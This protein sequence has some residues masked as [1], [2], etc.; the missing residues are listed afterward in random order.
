MGTIPGPIISFRISGPEL[1]GSVQPALQQVRQQAK[2]IS[3]GIADDWKRMA[4]QIRA[5]L[6]SGLSTDKESV[7]VRNQL[8]G[9]LDRQIAGYNKLNELSTKELSSLKAVTLERERQ[10]DAIRRGVGVGV[11][12]GTSSALGQVSAQTV[13]GIERI[14]DSVINRY[15]GGAAGAAARTVRDVGYYAGQASGNQSANPLSNIGAGL[16]GILGSVS[17][18]TLAVGALVTSFAATAGVLGT[19]T[20]SMI[21]Y[22]QSVQ[23]VS[24]A[25][26]LSYSETQKFRE[27]AK[28]T[29]VDAD[30]LTQSFGRLQAELGK[31]VIS[32]KD[33]E[34]ATQNFVKVLDRFGISATDSGGKLRP[35]GSIISDF[36][37]SLS[38]IPDAET[39]T[40]IGMDAMGTRG[41]ILV[42]VIDNLRASGM[43]LKQALDEVTKATISDAKIKELLA[44]KKS[45]DDL[46]VSVDAATLHVKSFIATSKNEIGLGGASPTALLSLEVAKRIS[47]F[48]TDAGA[49]STTGIPSAASAQGLIAEFAA[50]TNKLF[51]ERAEIIKDGGRA[52]YELLQ[53][54]QK[55]G[56]AVKASHGEDAKK[57]ADEIVNLK[58]VI[59]LQKEN[60]KYL[61]SSSASHRDFADF[62]RTPP[63]GNLGPGRDARGN[64]S[65]LSQFYNPTVGVDPLSLGIGSGGSTDFLKGIVGPAGKAPLDAAGLLAQ[66]NKEHEDLFKSQAAIDAEHYQ[67][68]LDSLNEALKKQLI[69]QQEY[70]DSVTKLAQDRNKTLSDADKKYEDEAGSLFDDLISG[71]GKKF[72][73]SLLKDVTDSALAPVKS[74]FEN[75]VGGQLKSVTDLFGGKSPSSP[76]GAAPSGGFLGGIFGKIGSLFGVGG[77][78]GTFPGAI[79]SGSGVGVGQSSVMN[80][81]AGVVNIMQG[82]PGGS[83][84]P[85]G[86]FPGDPFS[87]TGGTGGFGDFFGNTN[88]FGTAGG[89]L[90][91]VVSAATSGSSLGNVLGKLSPFAA[92][93]ALLGL[94]IGTGNETAIAM[95]AA[96]LASKAA[97]ALNT[98]GGVPSGASSFLSD[99]GSAGPGLGLAASGIITADKSNTV[100]G[101]AGGTFEAAAGGALAGAQFGGPIGAAIGW[102]VGLIGGVIADIFGGGPQGF[103]ASVQAAMRN[104][105]Y[106]APTSENFSFASNGSIANTLGTGFIQSGGKFSQYALPSNTSFAA[107]ALTG[108]LTWQQLYQLQNSG[109]NPNAPFLGNPSQNPYIGQGPVGVHATTPAPAVQIHVNLPGFVDASSAAA[110]FTPHA[111]LLTRLISA[112]LSSSSSGFGN[113]VRRAAYLP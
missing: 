19:V 43:T 74:I 15:L 109:L 5:S 22:A 110:A 30:G 75:V 38:E 93:G 79:G 102:S 6:A 111:Q 35:I 94:G 71:N 33:S 50:Q 7:G 29:G 42:Q 9:I 91:A 10:A 59:E 45:W 100:A 3:D 66:I 82:G 97:N 81:Q 57:Y 60:A 31:Y 92:G 77:T 58:A 73:T 11:T 64:A 80:V 84:V 24:A 54:E 65:A 55:Y 44:E 13:Q 14:L 87:G 105:Q 37:M 12:A 34:G 108:N 103:Q 61:F 62:L 28:I 98:I 47:S 113:N 69:S 107:S 26:G 83:L 70:N 49:P 23:N 56:E 52:E 106:H 99:F 104:N 4:A 32:G 17:P 2:S 78:P 36:A 88:P 112:Q 40:A 48:T 96:N 89:G 86:S 51:L 68:E 16:S 67:D 95:G 63:T 53:A 20:H 27:L 25:T 18:A 21:G 8:L 46:V 72:G 41:K 90:G 76:S 1:S 85:G 39:R 101:K